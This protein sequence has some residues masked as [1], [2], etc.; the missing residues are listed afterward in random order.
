[1][2]GGIW[3]PPLSDKACF[4]FVVYVQG[5]SKHMGAKPFFL[6]TELYLPSCF[7]LIL[8]ILSLLLNILSIFQNIPLS[9]ALRI[10]RNCLLQGVWY[11]V[12]YFFYLKSDDSFLLKNFYLKSDV[13]MISNIQIHP[14]YAT[15]KHCVK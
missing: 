6:H 10:D 4:L 1:M 3:T 12:L 11:I 2:Y 9:F 13:D 14:K 5:T 8:N 15:M 7:F